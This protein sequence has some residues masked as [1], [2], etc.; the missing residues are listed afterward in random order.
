[1]SAPKFKYRFA[2]LLKVREYKEKECQKEHAD[3]LSKVFR[4][5]EQLNGIDSDR[6]ETLDKQRNRQIGNIMIAEMLVCSRYLVKLKRDRLTGDEILHSLEKETEIKRL[7][8]VDAAR[9]RKIYVKLKEKLKTRYNKELD[10]SE[11]KELDEIASIGF[12]RKKKEATQKRA[13][14]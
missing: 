10:K 7:E 4:Q 6:L 11:Q 3:S 1:M 13:T 5:R 9:E 14:S 8:L 2:P 12:N